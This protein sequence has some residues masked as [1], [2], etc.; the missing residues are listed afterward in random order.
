M[1][2]T[3]TIRDSSGARR[4]VAR[5]A[6]SAREASAALRSEGALVLSLEAAPAV[7]RPG[8]PPFWHLSWLKPMGAFDVEI[9]LQQLASM[10]KS[11]VPLTV[12]LETVA[13]QALSPR[14]ARTWRSVL[15]IVEG[16]RPLS[17]AFAAHRRRFGDAAIALVRVGEQSGELDASLLHAARQMEGQRNLRALV[18]NALAYP[19]FAI[20]VAA[21]VCAFLVIGVIPKIA[22]FL[23]SGGATLPAMTQMLVDFSAWLRSNGAWLLAAAAVAVALLA[24]LRLIP[25]TRLALDTAA[26]RLPV[27]GRI[28]R[29]AGTAVF[30]RAMGM[31]VESGVTLLDALGVSRGLLRNRRLAQRV[32]EA[33]G[34]VMKGGALAPALKARGDFMPML[35]QM[36]AV[37]ETTGSL[38]DAFEE[39]ARFHELML[40]V[41]IRRFSV[42]IE[43]L[44]IVVTGLIVGYVYVA[45]F[46]ALFSIAGM[47]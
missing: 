37:G 3:A 23:E 32:R 40:A 5:E 4:N 47:G 10:I 11:G 39:V 22:A 25:P 27:A 14:S 9:G 20:V 46:M 29:L 21:G 16:G 33:S 2:F 17:E 34:A 26:L 30:S 24:V 31:L 28:G 41:A 7:A 35:S 12:A 18:V 43:P 13:D 8:G 45:F 15:G 36:V 6:A 42:T 44:M 1:L 19:A 38:S